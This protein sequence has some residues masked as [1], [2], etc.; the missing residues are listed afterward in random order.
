MDVR[1]EPPADLLLAMRSAAER[2]LV[3]RQYAEDFALVLD[4]VRPMLVA[5]NHRGWSLTDTIIHSHV[6][7][8]AQHGD[9]LIARKGGAELG[10]RAAAIAGQVLAAGGPG[11][12]AYFEALADFDFWLRSDGNRRN[13][14]S[15]ADVI[16]A[17]L[18]A[19]LRD[20]KLP[21]PWR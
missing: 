16:A 12:E 19:A 20:R 2:D 9:S 14:G 8:I 11:D 3:A 18:F 4:E 13:P 6:Q 17:A 7:L 1:D 10:Q 21:P 15:T 5:G